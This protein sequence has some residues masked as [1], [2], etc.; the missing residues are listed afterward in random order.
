M[1]LVGECVHIRS[2]LPHFMMW[3]TISSLAKTYFNYNTHLSNTGPQQAIDIIRRA[4]GIIRQTRQLVGEH[5]ALVGKCMAFFG[6]PTIRRRMPDVSRRM[7][8]HSLNASGFHDVGQIASFTKTYFN[9]NT[10]LS[11]IGSQQT[12]DIIR[13]AHGII[14]RTRPLVGERKALVGKCMTFFGETRK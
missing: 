8:A 9:D 14:R 3:N 13:R 5:T 4:H 11:N 1:T 2:T 7:R 12:I 6:E 10:H